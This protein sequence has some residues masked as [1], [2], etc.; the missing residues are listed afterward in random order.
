MPFQQVSIME[1]RKEFVILANKEGANVRE[2]CRRFQISPA[3]GYKWLNRFEAHGLQGLRDQSRRP[4]QS[5]LLTADAIEAQIVA[6]RQTHP[7]WGA[8]KLKRWLENKGVEALPAASTVHAILRRHGCISADESVAHQAWKRF[9]HPLPNDLWQMD[10]KGHFA[11]GAGRCHPLTVLDDHSRYV[12]CLGAQSNEQFTPTRERLI[13][14]FRR[15]G[16]PWRMTMDNGAPW[17]EP[18]RYTRFELWLMRLGIRVSHSR[19]YHPQTQGK[20]E[21]F[22]RTLKAEV[23]QQQTFLDLHQVQQKFDAWLPVYN[24]ERPHDALGLNTPTSRYTASARAYPEQLLAL[25]YADGDIVRKVQGGGELHYLGKEYAL[26]KAFTGEAV[27]LRKTADD[28][29]I[30]VHYGIYQVAIIE[31]KDQS[32]LI[33]KGQKNHS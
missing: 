23:L 30:Q 26:G 13:Q 5:P 21:R 32:I 9:E 22:H 1:Q 18:G 25:E 20:D 7:R 3:T 24:H 28:N 11:V 29:I 19:P 27:A 15:Y 4:E 16:L 14:T 12:L 17:G 31:L 2:L 10:F 33:K 6:A 8:R